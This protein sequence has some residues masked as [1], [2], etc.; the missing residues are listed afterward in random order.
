MAMNEKRWY[1]YILTNHTNTVLYIG[2]T[3]DMIRRLEEHRR[4]VGS[5]FT[6]KYRLYKLVWYEEF[7]SPLEAIAMEKRL[8]GWRREKGEVDR[9][10]ESAMARFVS[11]VVNAG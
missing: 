8:K 10:A 11:D 2:V 7:T 6:S 4:G 1:T 3:N 9:G 5:R